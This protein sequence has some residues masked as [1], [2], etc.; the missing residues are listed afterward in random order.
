MNPGRIFRVAVPS[1][2]FMDA[3]T[4][5]LGLNLEQRKVPLPH[6]VID[7]VERLSEN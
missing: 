6:I 2:V 7:R 5:E 1:M 4:K 3:V